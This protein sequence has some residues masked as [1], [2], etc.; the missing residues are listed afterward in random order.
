MFLVAENQEAEPLQCQVFPEIRMTNSI[1]FVLVN[2]LLTV[3]HF[4]SGSSIYNKFH[5][6]FDLNKEMIAIRFSL[7]KL[8]RMAHQLHEA[9]VVGELTLAISHI[10]GKRRVLFDVPCDVNR[11][12]NIA[13]IVSV[14]DVLLKESFPHCSFKVIRKQ[15]QQEIKQPVVLIRI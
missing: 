15:E 12:L 2:N 7:D 5:F 14:T 1:L 3:I 9:V 4:I 6:I 13:V 10:P 8:Y 11:S